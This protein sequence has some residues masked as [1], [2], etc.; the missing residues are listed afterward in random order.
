MKKIKIIVLVIFFSLFF[1]ACDSGSGSS[2]VSPD[3]SDII[4]PVDPVDPPGEKQDLSASSESLSF[5][6]G[7]TD[8]KILQVTSNK[9]GK[10][11]YSASSD[12][13]AVAKATSNSVGLVRV[14]PTGVGDAEVTIVRAKDSSYD[15]ASQTI[16]ISVKKQEQNLRVNLG[17][18]TS[19]R[20]KLKVGT[21]AT[22][23]VAA[24][25]VGGVGGDSD[26]V[27]SE[28]NYSV[29]NSNT[30]VVTA[31]VSKAADV[32]FGELTIKA[33]T[34]GDATVIVSNAGDNNYNGGKVVIFITV[35]EDATQAALNFTSTDGSTTDAD[36]TYDSYAAT[37]ADKNITVAGGSG[38]GN[39]SVKSS[40]IEIV[41]ATVD[42]NNGGLITIT[43][44]S[45][46]TAVIT[47]TRG[48]GDSGTTT[49]NPISKD[50]RVS[51]NK[52][53][54][55]ILILSEKSFMKIYKKLDDT[56]DSEAS[57]S[58]ST[59]D[60][61][62]KSSQPDVATASITASGAITVTFEDAGTTDIIITRAGNYGY[63]SSS[64]AI[65][66]VT[67]DK[68]PQRLVASPSS[69][70]A[71]YKK[72]GDT[73]SIT[74]TGGEGTGGFDTP[75]SDNT[76]VATASITES[77]TL[78][79]D[80]NLGGTTDITV[81]KRGDRN[82]KDSALEIRVTINR[83]PQT[84]SI[85]GNETNF[86]LE[87]GTSAK[88]KI[89][90]GEGTGQ[91]TTPVVTSTPTTPTT[92]TTPGVPAVVSASIAGNELTIQAVALGRAEIKF[93]QKGSRNYATSDLITI[94][95]AVTTQV[96]QV[97]RSTKSIFTATYKD[98]TSLQTE[99]TD[100]ITSTTDAAAYTVVSNSNYSVATATVDAVTNILTVTFLKVGTTTISV[101][102][103][104]STNFNPS[105][106]I[107]I[108][109][110]VAKASQTITVSESKFELDYNATATAS[111]AGGNLAYEIESIIPKGVV[112][113]SIV[114]NEL[115][116]IAV[117]IGDATISVF[118]SG[119]SNYNQSNILEIGVVV[120]RITQEL[121]A[122]RSTFNLVYN[123]TTTS[124]IAT[125][126]TITNLPT[127]RLDD[128]GKYVLSSNESIV[129]TDINQE[130]GL[131]SLRA[132]G[133]GDATIT[134]YKQ[135]D[136]R[137]LKSDPIEIGV[138]VIKA[139][140]ELISDIT[141]FS[142]AKPGDATTFAISGGLSIGEVYTA[143]SDNANIVTTDID[144]AGR[145]SITAVAAGD[146]TV[147][148]QRV[149]DANYNA[150]ADLTIRVEVK[151]QQIL[152]AGVVPSFKYKY[153]ESQNVV[154]ITGGQGAGR[155]QASST[156]TGI[157]DS[158][159]DKANGAL[160]ITT[161]STGDTTISIYKEGDEDYNRSNTISFQLS[162]LRGVVALGYATDAITIE[163]SPTIET[164]IDFVASTLK[165]EPTTVFTYTAATSD[166]IITG[167]NKKIGVRLDTANNVVVST[168]NADSAPATIRVT[169]AR[170][171]Y[172][173]QATA[174]ILVT[175]TQAKQPFRYAVTSLA[176]D[177]Q[178][179]SMSLNIDDASPGNNFYSTS[180]SQAGIITAGILN[181]G[182][183]TIIP[184]TGGSVLLTIT[185][186]GNINYKAATFEIQI[187]V[188]PIA[189]HL[190]YGALSGA[191]HPGGPSVTIDV[192]GT[193]PTDG[194]GYSI[195]YESADGT[196]V[197]ADI[198]IATGR[199]TITPI[200]IG[201]ATI[202]VNRDGNEN[203]SPISIELPVQSSTI[204]QELTYPQPIVIDRDG[205]A[206][207]IKPL[208]RT[209]DYMGGY[210]AA[211][212]QSTIARVDIDSKG[213]LTITP[214]K[215]A[216]GDVTV[217]ITAPA[218]IQ[219][220]FLSIDIKIKIRVTKEGVLRAGEWSSDKQ[221]LLSLDYTQ[222]KD[223]GTIPLS[224]DSE[225]TTTDVEFA[226]AS[227]NETIVFAE[228]LDS[229]RKGVRFLA[230]NNIM[231]D[232]TVTITASRP[233]RLDVVL[234][235]RVEVLGLR[236]AL[237][238]SKTGFTLN[239]YSSATTALLDAT[240]YLFT[241]GKD[242]SVDSVSA[243][244]QLTSAGGV[245]NI[246]VNSVISS[247][248][249]GVTYLFAASR[250][251][252]KVYSYQ[253]ATSDG[254]LTLKDGTPDNNILQIQGASALATAVI[255][256][257]TFLFVAGATDDGVSVFEVTDTGTLTYKTSISDADDMTYQI[258]G[259][260][261]LT[262]VVKD[263]KTFLVVAGAEEGFSIFEIADDGSL[264]HTSTLWDIIDS[265]I[266]GASSLTTID[267]HSVG[268]I[269]GNDFLFI[270]SAAEAK[271]IS[272]YDI[273]SD[274][275]PNNPT[276]YPDNPMRNL[277]GASS[278]TT[279]S[280]S[281]K[282]YLFVAGAED[283][284]VSVFNIANNGTISQANGNGVNLSIRD[285]A[286]LKLRG[287]SSV[288]TATIGGKVYLFVVGALDHSVSVFELK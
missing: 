192:D 141:S 17:D 256:D 73:T 127:D 253:V 129:T 163:Y 21:T 43:P 120:N 30:G 138:A 68:A 156:T 70:S 8:F 34:V 54:A 90:G 147:T 245:S 243:N 218:H 260:S 187:T 282:N 241:A 133:V 212:T 201:D 137:Y 215:T 161:V 217:R 191:L 287:A 175:V 92:P 200:G 12:N 194:G 193:T 272:K 140:Q 154:T 89:L 158:T 20:W 178:G 23:S 181:T 1:V 220:E 207:S 159:V 213:V 16:K 284:G 56:D 173:E 99:T 172:Y 85:E 112:T 174:D 41:T 27:G 5:T 119:N 61:Y 151:T 283:H 97:I 51:I 224:F 139:D 276:N 171:P 202:T 229:N 44:K 242:L 18:T 228:V 275:D 210:T 203:Y 148:I 113:A 236:L 13:E 22:I 258:G 206:V 46:G 238:D 83:V 205:S 162:V 121:T 52:P 49:Y 100:I 226:A 15:S 124:A 189:Q 167:G 143:T 182:A 7:E 36:V 244:G 209:P 98:L 239:P 102:K 29:E 188:N 150:A 125:I 157:V 160:S 185:R 166:N 197:T 247:K 76:S 288:T 130:S 31:T 144:S 57:G 267:A 4:D 80:L 214:T 208:T 261:S 246:N 11:K 79:V 87:T 252:S 257:K 271:G 104:G 250:A 280:F 285:D 24:K 135:Q 3:S 74:I 179:S 219:Y 277:N 204:A 177:Y 164:T 136:S 149:G 82:Y 180:L 237:T 195:T 268:G 240:T 221:N 153:K 196:I 251:D 114:N 234:V 222:S 216:T 278:V 33:L 211:T 19:D 26:L 107:S 170:T 255:A 265:N 28:G 186:N 9:A 45:A 264:S 25:S 199:V 146:A 168:L 227:S 254:A 78:T 286:T 231:G 259:T 53:A 69:I 118:D 40:N 152:S 10:G 155:Y 190:G 38:V 39:F 2:P 225:I 109:V 62:L 230:H 270:A 103:A 64:A 108:T 128:D 134:I 77:G 72:G 63:R 176:L 273:L 111:F 248:I 67:V 279:F 84:I 101:R 55:Q 233:N 106:T 165:I 86:Q 223:F 35:N 37:V 48:G 95:V 184:L 32:K 60:Y 115:S 131:L 235:L 232:A 6:F 183:L 117:G 142:F 198:D 42:T 274:G 14:R 88:V 110:T 269:M 75:T 47:V 93:M 71:I 50:I 145:L 262:T 169:R 116:I 122:S 249:G 58:S 281:S 263:S 66:D 94:T 105:N 132:V 91:Y 81:L 266:K 59:G 96:N 126:S 65:I 123:D